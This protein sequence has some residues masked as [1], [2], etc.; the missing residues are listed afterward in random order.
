[1]LPTV[2]YRHSEYEPYTPRINYEDMNAQVYVN[3]AG[4]A[5]TTSKG[6]RMARANIGV[7]EGDWYYECKV[8]R[9]IT[10]DGSGPGGHVRVGWARRE[11]TF[12]QAL[13]YRLTS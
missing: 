9:G 5:I 8:V 2:A 4:T 13:C 3:N 1:M 11:G 7:R 12:T 10:E 6:W